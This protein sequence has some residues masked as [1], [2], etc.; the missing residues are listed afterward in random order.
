MDAREG[1]RKTERALDL[2]A[3]VNNGINIFARLLA[4]IHYIEYEYEK[5]QMKMKQGKKPP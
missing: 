2:C 1:E 5:Q 4:R 3:R